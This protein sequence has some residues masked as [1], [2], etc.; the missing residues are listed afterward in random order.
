MNPATGGP[1]RGWRNDG[2]DGRAHFCAAN[3]IMHPVPRP[4][5]DSPTAPDAPTLR[6]RPPRRQVD[7][8]AI[9]L[10]SVQAALAAVGVVFGLAVLAAAVEP[11]RT[12]LSLAVVAAVV[13]GAVYVVAM[14]RIRYRVHRWEV[15][16]VAVYARSGWLTHEWRVAPLSRVQTVDARRSPLDQA[17]GLSSVRITTASA[18][19]D[20]VIDGLDHRLAADLVESLTAATQAT[21]GDAT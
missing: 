10:W 2:P 3:G 6:L 14:P 12:G 21:P 20:V 5:T 1:W 15:T 18:S 4:D 9:S 11:A 13:G 16:D 19:G 7:R 17:F 8:R